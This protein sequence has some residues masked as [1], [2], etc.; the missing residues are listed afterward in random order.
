MD[1]E[2][3]SALAALLS[4]LDNTDPSRVQEYANYLDLRS[5]GPADLRF[6]VSAVRS[7]ADKLAEI[8]KKYEA[9]P[10]GQT[11]NFLYYDHDRGS[12][13]LFDEQNP[14]IGPLPLPT[15][16]DIAEMLPGA[17][18]F[19]GGT[20]GALAGGAAG[21]VPGAIAGAGI[22][23]AGLR[24]GAELGM[25]RAFD[26]TDTRPPARQIIDSAI[27]GGLNAAG[28][29]GG[30]LAGAGLSRAWNALRRPAVT[31]ASGTLARTPGAEAARR[32]GVPLS[33][34]QT[35]E[36]QWLE[37][38]EAALSSTPG[39]SGVMSEFMGN[40]SDALQA[41][42]GRIGTHLGPGRSYGEAGEAILKG[43][44]EIGP[45]FNVKREALEDA[46]QAS[47]GGANAPVPITNVLTLA[48]KLSQ[49]LAPNPTVLGP[50]INPALTRI[51]NLITDA[52]GAGGRIPF[53]TLRTVRR[54]VGAAMDRPD[55]SGLSDVQ[56]KYLKQLYGALTED[57]GAAAAAGGPESARAWQ[58]LNRYIRYA[59]ATGRDVNLADLTRV[60]DSGS[61]DR[62]LK[63]VTSGDH[64][65]GSRLWSMRGQMKP[66]EWD[67]VA[68]SVWT[69]LGRPRANMQSATALGELTEEFSANSFL[70]N[71][72]KLHPDARKALF[73]GTRYAD[74]EGP[75][76]DLVRTAGL[77]KEAGK[78][79]NFSNTARHIMIWSGIGGMIGALGT[80][81][82]PAAAGVA[83]SAFVG[84][85]ATS[86]LLTSPTFV[87]WLA[88]AIK[89]TNRAPG[90]LPSMMARLALIAE[91]EPELQ[92][93][94]EAMYLTPFRNMM[95]NR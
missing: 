63:F 33:A 45:K 12:F 23:A 76:N 10:V 71:W 28:E 32:A 44:K 51:R 74:L 43:M 29:G 56:T 80:G 68:S 53:Q 19:V 5:G 36:K 50:E 57:M 11:G 7:R 34:G 8:R 93:S 22:G 59:R 85:Y 40:Q 35:A 89:V 70:T 21:G 37:S 6:R 79:Q 39:G 72:S 67:V 84:P 26:V 81:N 48:T 1:P 17:A 55:I 87:R 77:V 49:E 64:M 78:Y 46:L 82:L 83:G 54:S 94:I 65:S 4:R 15:G 73:G 9:V 2:I 62:A 61:V 75:I 25:Q 58:V 3:L 42:S 31:A 16:G 14:K 52:Q 18:E 69:E 30:R 90:Y 88:T 13:V 38:V 41:A 66:E 91:A 24:A 95:G 27:T 92:E 60:A 47:I 20:A 86:K